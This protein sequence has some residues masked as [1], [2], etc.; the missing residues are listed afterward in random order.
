MLNMTGEIAKL[1]P[2]NNTRFGV[3]QYNTNAEVP[4]P[5]SGFK[6]F[7]ELSKKINSIYYKPGGTRTDVAVTKA[8]EVFR[9]AYMRPA[10]KVRF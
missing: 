10:S 8:N 9:S 2:L 1:F 6:T 3:I 7:T 5:L 4:I